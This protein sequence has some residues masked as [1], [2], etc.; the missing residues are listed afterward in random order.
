MGMEMNERH[1]LANAPS[2]P[3]GILGSENHTLVT[4]DNPD[5]C[6][7]AVYPAI[8]RKM[9]S[10]LR[11]SGGR[12]L[13]RVRSYDINKSVVAHPAGVPPASGKRPV[14]HKGHSL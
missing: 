7:S 10:D 9:A 13:H 11:F 8:S 6:Q 12:R 2:G 5:P 4:H 3:T 14:E 1:G